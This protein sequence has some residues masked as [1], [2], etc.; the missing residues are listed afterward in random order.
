MRYK[1]LVASTPEQLTEQV[2]KSIAEGWKPLGG[3]SVAIHV[4][5]V[6]FCQAVTEHS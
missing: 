4:G 2:N 5:N 1:I 6:T 3:V